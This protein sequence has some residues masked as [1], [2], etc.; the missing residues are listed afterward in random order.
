MGQTFVCRSEC[1]RNSAANDR[2]LLHVSL[3]LRTFM[4][5]IIL[6][7]GFLPFGYRQCWESESLKL[8]KLLKRKGVAFCAAGCQKVLGTRRQSST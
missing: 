6:T 1:G 3:F 4:V 2:S 7:D 5:A 8:F